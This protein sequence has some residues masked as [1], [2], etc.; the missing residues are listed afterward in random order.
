MVNKSILIIS[1]QY[2]SAINGLG[3]YSAILGSYLEKRFHVIYAGLAQREPVEV[4]PYVYFSS[5]HVLTDILIKYDID[6]VFLNY[7]NFAYQRKGLPF[8]LLKELEQ[9]KIKGY[10]LCIFFHELNASSYKPWQ[11]VFWTKPLQQYIYKSL[12][13][14]A[15]IAFCSNERVRKIL[16]KHQH[17]NLYK[18]AI[19]ANIPEPSESIVFNQRGKSAIVFGTLNRRKKVY[20]NT[21]ELNAFIRSRNIQEIV[22]I[23]PGDASLAMQQLSCYKRILGKLSALE[24]AQEFCKHTWALIDYPPSL[25]EKSGI[26]AAY[27]A[28]GLVTYNTDFSD[29]IIQDFIDGKHYLSKYSL[30]HPLCDDVTLSKNIQLWY[31]E[32]SQANHSHFIQEKIEQILATS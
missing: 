22:D 16:A 17:P 26:F 23:G 28:Y 13:N 9:L 21:E 1:P 12:L 3:D 8:K 19:Y 7:V 27:A 18:K 2:P 10:K 11:L 32:H 15:D 30:D 29:H 4:S 5:W 25:I 24:I 31:E 6:C 14:I 20:E